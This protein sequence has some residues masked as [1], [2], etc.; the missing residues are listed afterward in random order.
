VKNEK[1]FATRGLDIIVVQLENG[2]Q[3]KKEKNYIQFVA[4]WHL[5]KLG[6]PMTYFEGLKGFF[7]FLKVANCLR[8]Q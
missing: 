4:I 6:C 5:L 1:L 8:K 7:K 3:G 2:G